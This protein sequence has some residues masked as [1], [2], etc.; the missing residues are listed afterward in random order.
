MNDPTENI[1]RQMV[2]EINAEPGSR[3]AL[4]QKY[5]KVWDMT[6][7][8]NDFRA[9]A[10]MATLIIVERKSDGKKGTLTFQHRPRYYFAWEED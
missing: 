9:L 10:F 1:R 7:M 3:E 4:E 2:N 8:S 5:G 6:E